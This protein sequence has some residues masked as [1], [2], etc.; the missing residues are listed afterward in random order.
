MQFFLITFAILAT[1]VLLQF[2]VAAQDDDVIV[3]ETVT[4]GPRLPRQRDMFANW[5][6]RTAA[7][8]SNCDPFLFFC[9]G[10]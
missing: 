9:L 7:P 2:H 8:P 10:K 6:R 3:E 5:R 1:T 4:Q